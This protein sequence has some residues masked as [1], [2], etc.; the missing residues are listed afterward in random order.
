MSVGLPEPDGPMI[1][2]YSPR[3]IENVTPRSARTFSSPTAYVFSMS[4]ISISTPASAEHRAPRDLADHVDEPEDD[5]RRHRGALRE[6]RQPS[7]AEHEKKERR[8]RE[9]VERAGE[10]AERSGRGGVQE[11]A[12]VR[13][14]DLPDTLLSQ[15]A[16]WELEKDG[17]REERSEDVREAGVTPDRKELLVASIG[18]HR[19]RRTPENKRREEEEDRASGQGD[20]EEHR[21]QLLRHLHLPVDG[22]R[23]NRAPA[24]LGP[25]LDGLANR[26][27]HVHFRGDDE[28]R[29]RGRG[30]D[31]HEGQPPRGPGD[32]TL[33]SLGRARKRADDGGHGRDRGLGRGN[34]RGRAAHLF[35]L[36][37]AGDAP[38]ETARPSRTTWLTSRMSPTD[39]CHAEMFFRYVAIACSSAVTAVVRSLAT[40]ATW[41]VVDMPFSNFFFSAS[42]FRSASSRAFV[43]AA[44]LR[45][46]MSIARAAAR[47]STFR[48]AFV[49]AK[50][51]RASSRSAFATA[52]F[53]RATLLPIGTTNV[54]PSVQAG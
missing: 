1:A 9:D 13:L 2:T 34:G 24:L 47:T 40:W 54:R 53:P 48:F 41:N 7:E 51:V 18:S 10:R 39:L 46:P 21:H 45:Y 15:R 31:Q 37:S 44:T 11:G 4:T 38:V 19:L 16:V 17:N 6:A 14:D 29:N 43:A 26:T 33:E 32:E 42:R 5:R 3:S 25:L 49:I 27:V 23:R 12:H 36:S 20:A 52:S 22:L 35:G 50:F 28:P 8:E 30:D